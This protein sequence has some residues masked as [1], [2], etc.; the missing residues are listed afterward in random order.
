MEKNRELPFN[1]AADETTKRECVMLITEKYSV[2]HAATAVTD[3]NDYTN[4][5]NIIAARESI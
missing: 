4:F 1:A 2:T 3:F 5:F